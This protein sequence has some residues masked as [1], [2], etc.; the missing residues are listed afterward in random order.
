MF[1]SSLPAVFFL[2]VC[3]VSI[4]CLLTST[5]IPFS[6]SLTPTFSLLS[7][8]LLPALMSLPFSPQPKPPHSSE[9]KQRPLFGACRR[10]LFKAC[11]TLTTFAPATIPLWLLWSTRSRRF[12][13]WNHLKC[14]ISLNLLKKNMYVCLVAITS[15]S[16]TGATKRSCCQFIRTWLMPWGSTP[17]WMWLSALRHCALPLTAQWRSCSTLR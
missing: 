3:A 11:W 5:V 13:R 1:F 9:N 14:T 17:R 4:I 2:S 15:K 6:L 8:P 10:V 7:L 12:K 16:S